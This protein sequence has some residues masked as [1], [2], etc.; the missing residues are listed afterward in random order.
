VRGCKPEHC[1]ARIWHTQAVSDTH[2]NVNCDNFT[3][4]GH[5]GADLPLRNTSG[6]ADLSLTCAGVLLYQMKESTDVACL[7]RI[8]GVGALPHALRPPGSLEHARHRAVLLRIGR[9]ASLSLDCYILSLWPQVR[10]MKRSVLHPS[11]PARDT[12]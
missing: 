9:M 6:N 11:I 3:N 10:R 8:D 1:A 5:D 12:R 2:K 4:A 7:Q